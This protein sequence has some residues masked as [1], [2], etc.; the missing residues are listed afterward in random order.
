MFLEVPLIL[1]VS[2]SGLNMDSDELKINEATPY[3]FIPGITCHTAQTAQVDSHRD[4]AEAHNPAGS[5][6]I[7]VSENT[8]EELGHCIAA[9]II[10]RVQQGRWV[11]HCECETKD[12]APP[13]DDGGDD[14]AQNPV[15]SIPVW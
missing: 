4:D 5:T 11:D 1:V 13:H 14:R 6:A 2:I 15:G 3:W 9:C 12:V 10:C 8:I 7:P